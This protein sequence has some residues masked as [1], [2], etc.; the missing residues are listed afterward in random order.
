[1]DSGQIVVYDDETIC[2]FKQSRSNGQSRLVGYTL[3]PGTV[4][5]EKTEILGP[6]PELLSVRDAGLSSNS[7]LGVTTQFGYFISSGDTCQSFEIE[8]LSDPGVI[9]DLNATYWDDGKTV[10]VAGSGCRVLRRMF[11]TTAVSVSSLPNKE[12]LQCSYNSSNDIL[13]L[14][15]PRPLSE[16][17]LIVLT[18]TGELVYEVDINA[19][20]D[21]PLARSVHLNSGTY[22]AA[23]VS[24]TRAESVLFQVVR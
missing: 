4:E 19:V 14:Y 21:G 18:I 3:R 7:L 23:V 10:I 8:K 1:M 2:F 16:C 9:V 11:H 17:R 12:L 24:A 22:V 5:F 20:H 13:S 6:T 15:A